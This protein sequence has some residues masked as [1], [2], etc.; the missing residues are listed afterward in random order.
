MILAAYSQGVVRYSDCFLIKC[1]GRWHL[2][3]QLFFII[4]AF[5][6]CLKV[7]LSIYP[8]ATDLSTDHKPN[9]PDEL[10][11][12]Q[13]AG[14]RVTEPFRFAGRTELGSYRVN[15]ILPMSRAIGIILFDFILVSC[16]LS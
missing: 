1:L 15:G 13:N 12:I 4:N 3:V 7:I 9:L 8:K 2:I 6:G 14:G 5:S 16:I 11:R 10:R